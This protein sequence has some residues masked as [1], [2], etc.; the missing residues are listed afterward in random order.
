MLFEV[1]TAILDPVRRVELPLLLPPDCRMQ[2]VPAFD[3]LQDSFRTGTVLTVRYDRPIVAQTHRRDMNV[4]A[5]DVPV[6]EYIVGLLPEAHAL[7]ILAGN[8]RKL[9][10]G[11]VIPDVRIQRYMEYRV[12]DLPG[13]EVRL[14]A[15]QRPLHIEPVRLLAVTQH[16]VAV[17]NGSFALTDLFG[18]V[19]QHAANRRAFGYSTDHL[20]LNSSVSFTT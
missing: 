17:Q 12:F 3:V 19:F 9:A 20:R 18:V 7:H 1:L 11:Q 14:K 13:I 2:A 10:V 16:L 5:V 6:F 8:I 15:Q 4:C